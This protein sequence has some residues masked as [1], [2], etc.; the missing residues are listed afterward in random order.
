MA[1][2]RCSKEIRI[3]QDLSATRTVCLAA[4]DGWMDGSRAHDDYV[5]VLLCALHMPASAAQ[6]CDAD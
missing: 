3:S 1:D 5:D 2:G 4:E 6:A